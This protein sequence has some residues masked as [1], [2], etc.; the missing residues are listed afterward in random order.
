M[1]IHFMPNI[2]LKK[3]VDRKNLSFVE[4]KEL[5]LILI[6]AE[7]SDIETSSIL[8]SLQTK[9]V[10]RDELAGFA[11]V[12]R[13]KSI[14]INPKVP[15]TFDLCGTGGDMSNTFNI[16]TTVAFVLAA[17]G[18]IVAKHGG[19][20]SSSQ[21]GSSDVLAALGIDINLSKNDIENCIEK[22]GIG[23]IFAPNFHPAFKN[24]VPIRKVLQIP[25]I[26]NLL[27]PLIN[28]T[29]PKCQVVGVYDFKFLEIYIEV[30]EMLGAEHAIVLNGNGLDEASICDETQI[31]ELENERVFDYK[32]KPE[33]FGFERSSL[34]NLE[35]GDSVMNAEIL[36]KILKN[37]ELGPKKDIVLLNAAVCLK[38]ANKVLSIQ[39][40]IEIAREALSSGKAYAKLQQLKIL[41]TNH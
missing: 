20:A 22:V 9:G 8:S 17:C 3:I 26:F 37:E 18:V 34:K 38:A 13:E 36:E 5:A 4:S 27:G 19:R 1:T 29:S 23:F 41:T 15:Y 7:I 11:E 24:I 6:N 30:L 10:C 16:S 2:F 31:Y 21:C 12:F 39:S 14:K 28:P 25:T 32:I 33:E 40:G 35:G